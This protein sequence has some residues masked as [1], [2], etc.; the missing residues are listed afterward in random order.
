[1]EGSHPGL[2]GKPEKIALNV[3][4]TI[5]TDSYSFPIGGFSG[6]A[7]NIAPGLEKPGQVRVLGQLGPS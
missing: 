5:I 2:L 3:F 4:V 7:E 6:I 1:M